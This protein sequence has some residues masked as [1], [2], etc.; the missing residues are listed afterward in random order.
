MNITQYIPILSP[1]WY[2]VENSRN[3]SLLQTRIAAIA[4]YVFMGLTASLAVGMSIFF[5]STVIL[6]PALLVAGLD[7]KLTAIRNRILRKSESN[8]KVVEDLGKTQTIL[9]Q[10]LEKSLTQEQ[11]EQ[12]A[13][14]IVQEAERWR[15]VP[16]TERKLEVHLAKSLPIVFRTIVFDPTLDSVIV[17]F[18]RRMKKKE[19]NRVR[20]KNDSL[21]KDPLIE[22]GTTKTVTYATNLTRNE[23]YAS[24]GMKYCE[25]NPER[26]E[27]E[28]EGYKLVNGL[29]GCLP[30]LSHITYEDK[31]GNEK[32]RLFMPYIAGGD[33]LLLII[34]KS[35][36]S[37]QQWDIAEQLLETLV[38]LH[39]RKKCLHRDIKPENVLVELTD[40][41]VKTYFIDFG[42]TCKLD[43]QVELKNLRGTVDFCP[44]EYIFEIAKNTKF[45]ETPEGVVSDKVDVWSLGILILVLFTGRVL[46]WT[47]ETPRLTYYALKLHL[48]NPLELKNYYSDLQIAPLLEKMLEIDPKKRLRALDALIEFRKLRYLLDRENALQNQGETCSG[49]EIPLS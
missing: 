40:Q 12:F 6:T 39:Q 33:L 4:F 41:K 15:K 48:R 42:Y 38:L 23:R 16:L 46:P 10:N 32:T 2:P 37:K 5:L 11:I 43:D 1:L 24:A 44:P 28:L 22:E 49:N 36:S 19:Q 29:K 47:Q 26:V 9:Q 8:P 18:N 20:G 35:L 17:L 7:T 30:L 14:W 31:T 45:G 34:N 25:E 27:K 21:V 13:T 3:R